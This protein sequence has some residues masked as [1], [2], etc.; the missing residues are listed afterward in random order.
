MTASPARRTRELCKGKIHGKK[1]PRVYKT[2]HPQPVIHCSSNQQQGERNSK[3]TGP[4]EKNHLNSRDLYEQ[5][6]VP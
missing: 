2:A 4:N 5:P 3:K 1:V 6:L